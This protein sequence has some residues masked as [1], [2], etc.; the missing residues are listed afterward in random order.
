MTPA[1]VTVVRISGR[2]AGGSPSPAT[3]SRAFPTGF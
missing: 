3:S 1:L 2:A